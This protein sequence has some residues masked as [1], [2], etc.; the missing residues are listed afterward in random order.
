MSVEANKALAQRYADEVINQ[1][2]LDVIDE[3]CTTDYKS[4]PPGFPP[5]DREGDKQLIAMFRAAFPDMRK[6]IDDMVADGDKVV[7]RAT[8]SGTHTGEFQGIPPTGRQAAF[9]G[10]HIFRIVDGKIAETRGIMDQLGML[11]Q[12][13]VIPAPEQ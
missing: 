5:T 3:I 11:Q 2:K 7:E 8:Y 13:G 4:Y 10:M 12:L 1:G 6:R 9:T